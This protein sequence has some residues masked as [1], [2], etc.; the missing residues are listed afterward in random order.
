LRRYNDVC[1]LVNENTN[2]EICSYKSRV[3]Q[4]NPSNNMYTLRM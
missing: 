1:L 4:M 3:F 2:T